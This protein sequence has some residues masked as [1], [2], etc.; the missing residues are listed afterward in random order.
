MKA[1]FGIELLIVDGDDEERERE[2]K[3]E[4]MR[5][6]LKREERGKNKKN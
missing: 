2:R 4:G 1:G 3:S 6:K 5:E